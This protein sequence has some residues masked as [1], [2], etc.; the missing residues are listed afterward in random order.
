MSSQTNIH[1]LGE[2]LFRKFLYE[3]FHV[4][5][6]G[7]LH[8]VL[9]IKFLLFVL[10]QHILLCEFGSAHRFVKIAGG[11]HVK[12]ILKSFLIVSEFHFYHIQFSFL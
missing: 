12:D 11:Y 8:F 7:F 10:K 3:A 6:A 9:I 5:D 1:G 2:E 4:S